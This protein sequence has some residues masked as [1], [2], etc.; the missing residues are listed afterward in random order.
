MRNGD[1][2]HLVE[3][4]ILRNDVEGV[5]DVSHVFHRCRSDARLAFESVFPP[6][7]GDGPRGECEVFE[8]VHWNSE[9]GGR[10]RC[11]AVRKRYD[12][13]EVTADD[14]VG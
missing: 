10:G 4:G 9:Y 3:Y 11:F 14:V 1:K 13:P 8:Q 6:V 7:L 2:P 12:V 5:R